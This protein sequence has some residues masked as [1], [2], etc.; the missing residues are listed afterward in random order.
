MS[1]RVSDIEPLASFVARKLAQ[2]DS[3]W[4]TSTL[5]FNEYGKM[6]YK[7]FDEDLRKRG[8]RLAR[9]TE[10]QFSQGLQGVMVIKE[11]R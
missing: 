1:T 6:D 4:V 8:A 2:G 7:A 3:T 10:G 11:M 9:T 5:I